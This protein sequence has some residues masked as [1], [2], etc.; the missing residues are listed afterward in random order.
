MPSTV[1]L[2]APSWTTYSS[3]FASQNL[4]Q[5]AVDA[6]DSTPESSADVKKPTYGTVVV[7][8]RFLLSGSKIAELREKIGCF[9][10][11]QR[12]EATKEPPS[13]KKKATN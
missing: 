8:K 12:I 9:R 3:F 6:E 5:P 10:G 7:A 1:S 13:Q 4:P 11:R 2:R